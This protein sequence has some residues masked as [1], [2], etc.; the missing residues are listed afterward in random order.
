M[1][2]TFEKIL[3]IPKSFY[4]SWRFCSDASPWKLPL[5]VRYNTRLLGRGL[6]SINRGGRLMIG[7]GNV[8][9]YVK[10]YSPAVLEVYGKI[11]VEGKV[12]LG[13]GAKVCVGKNSMLNIGNN[14]VNTAEARIVCFNKMSIGKNTVLGWEATLMDT[15]FHKTEN[16]STGELSI[17]EKEIKIGEGVWIGLRATILKGCQ[18][19]NGCIVAACAVVA[20]SFVDENA[21]LAGNPAVVKKIGFRLHR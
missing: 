3:S 13:Q 4:A 19:A 7:F 14:V 18:I 17:P 5:L 6:I 9:L 15:D 1:N 11:K 12:Y 2:T 21:I 20:K 8:G 16:V 10:C